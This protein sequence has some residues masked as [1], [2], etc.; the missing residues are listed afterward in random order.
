LQARRE[1]GYLLRAQAGKLGQQRVPQ[2]ACPAIVQQ[3]VDHV[4]QAMARAKRG[5]ERPEGIV[6][7]A[8]ALQFLG[9]EGRSQQFA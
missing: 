7:L 1:S 2:Q 3:L 8:E 6:V 9:S 5:D 4:V